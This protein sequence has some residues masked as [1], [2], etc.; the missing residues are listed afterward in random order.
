MNGRCLA[1]DRGLLLANKEHVQPLIEALASMRMAPWN[2]WRIENPSIRPDLLEIDL[3][4]AN[5]SCANMS[6]ADISRAD[7]SRTN[8][9]HANLR[10]ADLSSTNLRGADLSK[11]DL[12][13]SFLKGAD[14][15]GAIL[16]DAILREA[17]LIGA[18]LKHA[19][20]RGAD[21]ANALIDPEAIEEHKISPG[22]GI[23][24]FEKLALGLFAR[25]KGKLHLP[26]DSG[27]KPHRSGKHI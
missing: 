18:N 17:N 26:M 27:T 3:S 4:G 13:G 8:L 21:L 14:L 23:S 12:T 11:A 5:L 10:H 22:G 1:S 16:R 19:D 6:Y 20:L 7:L 25:A 24:Y 15:S 9:Y 2:Y